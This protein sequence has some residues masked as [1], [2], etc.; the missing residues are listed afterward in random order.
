MPNYIQA[1]ISDASN[2]TK[3]ITNPTSSLH[4]NSSV[5]AFLYNDNKKF[6]SAT[7]GFGKTYL[8]KLKSV[9]IRNSKSGAIFIP[10]NELV[11][12][13]G[14]M[15]MP[16]LSH[17]VY[18]QYNSAEIHELLWRYTF[19]LTIIRNSEN[20]FENIT[21]SKII[22]YP[23]ELFYESV[24]YPAIQDIYMLLLRDYTLFN[25][26]RTGDY[27][28]QFETILRNS[29]ETFYLFVDN[30]DEF[31]DSMGFIYND[32]IWYSAQISL[33][34]AVVKLTS[35]CSHIHIYGTIRKKALDKLRKK[36][37][38]YAQ[39]QDSIVELRYTR[40][41]L[42][43]IFVNN[44]KHETKQNLKN[45]SQLS[46]AKT[47]IDYIQTFI[48]FDTITNL[49]Q[50]E[51]KKEDLF[52]YIYRH[53]LGR[54][55]DLMKMGRA[56]S[57]IAVDSRDEDSIRKT[58]NAM[59]KANGEQ[60]I[61][62]IGKFTDVDFEKVYRLVEKNILRLED[63]KRS[64]CSYNDIEDQE[65]NICEEMH[66]FCTLYTYGLIGIEALNIHNHQCTIEFQTAGYQ[67]SYD[68]SHSLPDSPRYF[69]HPCLSEIIESY[70]NDKNKDIS[71]Y[72][73]D[74]DIIVGY[75]V[76]VECSIKVPDM[77]KIPNLDVEV[78]SKLVTF[79]EY[80]SYCDFTNKTPPY[81]E[82]WGRA[83]RPVV[84]ISWEE[85][86]AYS[87][88]LSQKT[89]QRYRLPSELEWR[90]M[91]GGGESK[92]SFGDDNSQLKKY[93]WYKEN[94][95]GMTHTVATL[96]P[97]DLGIYDIYGNVWEWC[98][99]SYDKDHQHRIVQGGAFDSEA[100]DTYTSVR[101]S[102][103]KDRC[104]NNIGFRLVREPKGFSLR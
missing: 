97:N 102:A 51:Q 10:K 21:T 90:Q 83:Q 67:P 42:E 57:Q 38:L 5:S 15:S 32:D 85:A 82:G 62:E 50:R 79:K 104:Y 4:I 41:D 61:N 29:S 88:W 8:L 44:I 98:N 46:Y 66:I 16:S 3:D 20:L 28:G 34:R 14:S 39:Y 52:S 69:I 1:W 27:M 13:I 25:S 37:S 87:E 30:V 73:Y 12:R 6:I 26:M 77:I 103:D 56:I 95:N 36:D 58:I 11:D 96:K 53:T 23:N 74:R 84:N 31:Y 19:I 45:P 59:A 101:G 60:Y 81:D 17:E 94:S 22:E 63:I 91:C 89:K 48:G 18:N 24:D 75:D 68:V 43:G 55:R 78:S 35:Q 33:L 72:S 71:E 76:K 86:V 80:D 92:W 93:A 2:I 54:P 9:A 49:F 100:Y 7:K 64:C 65:C 40:R 70:R 47:T 99:D